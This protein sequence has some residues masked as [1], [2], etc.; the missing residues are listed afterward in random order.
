MNPLRSVGARLSL[1]LVGVVLLAL[2]LVYLVVVPS[3]RNRLIDAKLTQL[4]KALPQIKKEVSQTQFRWTDN[5]QIWSSRSDARV[6]IYE[7]NTSASPGRSASLLPVEDSRT[8]DSSDVKSDSV[9]Q[10]AADTFK[11]TSGTVR[12]GDE[13][14]AEVAVP[15]ASS[16]APSSGAVVLLS[17][18]LGDALD[19]VHTVQRRVVE[20]GLL[21]L[22][23]AL[24][25]GY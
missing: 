3:L 22:L 12:R 10:R 21:A 20:A 16:L 18:S 14:F 19:N 8:I 9:A 13:E 25:L 23:V 6:V 7:I 15:A 1:A 24:V 11:E 4:S 17:A 2:G 5:L